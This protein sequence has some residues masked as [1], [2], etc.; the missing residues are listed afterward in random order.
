MKRLMVGT[1]LAA[2][3]LAA[4][5][6]AHA[7]G[8]GYLCDILLFPGSGAKGNFGTLWTSIYSGPSCTGTVVSSGYVCTQGAT[9]TTN[10]PTYAQ[11]SEMQFNTLFKVAQGA[12][13]AGSKVYVY[14]AGTNGVYAL[15][16]YAPGF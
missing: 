8:Y 16:F 2:A 10:C 13:D 6:A 12:L 7:E 15:T 1:L 14:T 3:L 9:D 11:Y 4:P 5:A